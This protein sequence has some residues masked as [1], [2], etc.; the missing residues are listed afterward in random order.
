M[1]DVIFNRPLQ[2]E[3]LEA[4]LDA[5]EKDVNPET[6]HD[7]IAMLGAAQL[8]A[9]VQVDAELTD[10][11]DGTFSIDS[12]VAAQLNY[13][14]IQNQKEE[15]FFPAFTSTEEYNKWSTDVEGVVG[16]TVSLET[17]AALMSANPDTGLVINAFGQ[18]V[19]MN[20]DNMNYV[21]ATLTQMR[22]QDPI[23]LEE[24]VDD[25]SDFAAKLADQLPENMPEM[26]TVWAIDLVRAPER[27]LI[28]VIH[29]EGD[30]EEAKA[31]FFAFAT[32]NNAPAFSN[33]L[34]VEEIG[35]PR[36]AAFTP[37]YNKAN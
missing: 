15:V 1:A 28:Y 17:Y 20:Q 3:D 32:I 18:N 5:Y 35:Y 16:L 4:T 30:P 10:N 19:V 8:L 23:T 12:E 7:F 29:T 13:Q 34:S 6:E 27:T 22:E 36:A 37:I 11:G 26:N 25:Q 33:V 2:N 21:M 14:V 31:Q 9:P 24:P